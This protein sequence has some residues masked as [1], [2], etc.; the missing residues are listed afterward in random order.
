VVCHYH[1]WLWLTDIGCEP[2]NFPCPGC[3]WPDCALVRAAGGASSGP[4]GHVRNIDRVHK[5]TGVLADG[6]LIEPF[7]RL[8]SD[9]R[10][11]LNDKGWH[12][13]TGLLSLPKES[14]PLLGIE[15][16]ETYNIIPLCPHL[17][18]G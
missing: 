15:L 16:E 3:I 18:A 1:L 4:Y 6:S 7:F 13:K 9:I 10:L 5:E 11:H 12:E 17:E 14:Q 8:G 2:S